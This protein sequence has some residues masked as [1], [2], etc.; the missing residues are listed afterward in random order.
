MLLIA[1][2][3]CGPRSSSEFSYLGEEA[4]RPQPAT[5]ASWRTYL[6]EHDNVADWQAERWF[7]ANGCRMF[8][9]VE[10]HTVTNEIRIVRPL[11]QDR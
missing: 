1:C 4:P 6:Y 3:Y 2:P 8:I 7:H 11:G 10:R 9:E 5:P